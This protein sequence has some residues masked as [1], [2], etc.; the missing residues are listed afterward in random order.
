MEYGEKKALGPKPTLETPKQTWTPNELKN[1]TL[2]RDLDHN[3]NMSC[4]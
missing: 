2:D 3:H 1:S 4:G